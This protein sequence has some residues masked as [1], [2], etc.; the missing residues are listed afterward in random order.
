MFKLFRLNDYIYQILTL[1]I[2]I[3]LNQ[4]KPFELIKSETK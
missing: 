2:Y 1:L 4:I 3:V